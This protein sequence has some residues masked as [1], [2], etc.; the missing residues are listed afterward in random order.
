MYSHKYHLVQKLINRLPTIY[1]YKMIRRSIDISI[2]CYGYP[3]LQPVYCEWHERRNQQMKLQNAIRTIPYE[4]VRIVYTVRENRI[5]EQWT[6]RILLQNH[7]PIELFDHFRD[8]LYVSNRTEVRRLLNKGYSRAIHH[9]IRAECIEPTQVDRAL[10]IGKIHDD[11]RPFYT[12]QHF[13][14]QLMTCIAPE[15]EFLF[16]EI[17]ESWWT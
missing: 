14:E 5:R 10:S 4:M 16:M 15:S 13:L 12:V 8:Y 7:I 17:C 11:R 1:T 3:L 6:K 9:L 2:P